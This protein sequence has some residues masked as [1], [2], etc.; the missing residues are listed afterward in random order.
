[1]TSDEDFFRRVE[2]DPNLQKTRRELGLRVAVYG[3][4]RGRNAGIQLWRDTWILREPASEGTWVHL[5]GRDPTRLCCQLDVEVFPYQPRTSNLRKRRLFDAL[6]HEILTDTAPVD[7][8]LTV[9][10]GRYDSGML[11]ALGCVQFLS[12]SHGECRPSIEEFVSFLERV[13]RYAVPI[14]DGVLARPA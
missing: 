5:E 2:S 3:P 13:V 14:V 12:S 6:R 10:S 8:E 1:M 4:I 9:C 11:G 7:S